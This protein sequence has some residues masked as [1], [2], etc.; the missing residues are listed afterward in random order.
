MASASS[1][2]LAFAPLGTPTPY[3]HNCKNELEQQNIIIIRNALK[4]H[5]DLSKLAERYS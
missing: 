5:T 2:V 1:G 4:N 3:Y